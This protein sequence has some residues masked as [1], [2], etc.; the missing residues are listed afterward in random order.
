M[1]ATLI[2]PAA[3]RGRRMGGGTPKV[4]R[5]LRGVPVL[6]RTLRR[7]AA[8][9]IRHMALKGNRLR[10]MD[11]DHAPSRRGDARLR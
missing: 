1:R 3:G 9:E 4:Y 8:Q 11:G 10:R 7:T 5:L 6:L 2:I